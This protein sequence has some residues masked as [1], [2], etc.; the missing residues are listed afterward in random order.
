MMVG[1]GKPIKGRIKVQGKRKDKKGVPNDW[2]TEEDIAKLKEQLGEIDGKIKISK[3]NFRRM[4]RELEKKQKVKQ[5]WE[6]KCQQI[7][8][9]YQGK[10]KAEKE[11]KE[12]LA[13]L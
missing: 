8:C 4:E 12:T 9:Q 2:V 10:R 3:N 5:Q 11:K 7:D 1:G 6:L 13:S